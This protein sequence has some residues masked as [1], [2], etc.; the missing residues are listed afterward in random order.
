MSRSKVNSY[1]NQL[2]KERSNKK[3]ETKVNNKGKSLSELIIQDPDMIPISVIALIEGANEDGKYISD[4]VNMYVNKSS[5]LNSIPGFIEEE[6]RVVTE[7]SGDLV[8][9]IEDNNGIIIPNPTIA[10]L[11]YVT[12][13]VSKLYS[14]VTIVRTLDINKFLFHYKKRNNN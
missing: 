13:E 9:D 8:K 2:L 4:Y 11:E 12:E 14:I 1:T 5:L 3:V 10:P 7:L 6:D